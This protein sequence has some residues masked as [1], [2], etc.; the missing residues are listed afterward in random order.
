MDKAGTFKIIGNVDLM[1][2]NRRTGKVI[3][4]K[5]IPNIICNAGLVVLAK[6]LNGVTSQAFSAIA[7]GTDNTT[8]N[9]SDTTLGAEVQRATAEVSYE[10][11]YKALFSYEFTFVSSATIWEVGLFDALTE[12][13]MLNHAIDSLGIGVDSDINLTV[14]I[15]ITG[16]AGS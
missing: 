8:A 2:R 5:T 7:I 10:A 11:D 13:N 16:S 1:T 4:K 9:A 15:T 14:D 6:L 12:G 3:E